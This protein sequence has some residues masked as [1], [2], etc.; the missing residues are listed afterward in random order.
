MALIHQFQRMTMSTAAQLVIRGYVPQ[1]TWVIE[2]VEIGAVSSTGSAA[3]Q[4]SIMREGNATKLVDGSVDA[5]FPTA[6]DISWDGMITC[7]FG[8]QIVANIT[9]GTVGDVYELD[10]FMRRV[11]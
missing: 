1:G 9:N 6:N 10:T 4:L 2:H 11:A 3:V 5:N 8:D 7:E